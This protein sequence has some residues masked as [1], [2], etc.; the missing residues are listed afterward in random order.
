[1]PEGPEVALF[2]RYLDQHVAGRS[3]TNLSINSGSRYSKDGLSHH[4]TLKSLLP[5]NILK[6]RSRGKKIVFELEKDVALVSTLGLEGK[7]TFD[8]S[9]KHGNLWLTIADEFDRIKNCY[10]CDS[11]HF[12][13]LTIHFSR[14][15]LDERLFEIGPDLLFDD[16]T[17]KMWMDKVRS[18]RLQKLQIC[19]FL[20]MQQH[21]S[22][23]G[24]YVRAEALYRAKVRPDA[25]LFELTEEDHARVLHNVV[26]VLK[27][28]YE[29]QGASLH[30]FHNFDGTKGKFQVVVYNHKTDPN[31][32]PVISSIFEDGRNIYWVPKVQTC[33][34]EYVSDKLV[35][36]IEK[37]KASGGRGEG[38]Y[39]VVNLKAFAKDRGLSTA[40]SKDELLKRLISDLSSSNPIESHI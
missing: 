40:G 33:P 17:L 12:G 8:D 5:L 11:R 34:T 30:T 31:G 39:S 18:N 22:G 26:A 21:F 1:M 9:I 19:N 2:A 24:N 20:L 28:S 7:W 3:L 15:S 25:R 35:I 37:L 23:V 36:D 13:S 16:V 29:S 27:E 32:H 6:V 4:E 10:Y 38:K 14:G